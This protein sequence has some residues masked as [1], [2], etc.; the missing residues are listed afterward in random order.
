M[1][2]IFTQNVKHFTISS[3]PSSPSTNLTH[4]RSDLALNESQRLRAI[5]VDILL[6]G[7]GVIAIAAVRV[8][9]VAVRLDDAGVGGRAGEACWA[10]GKLKCV[11][12]V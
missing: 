5:L 12:K 1:I 6:M 9:G 4:L 10:G 3:P 8:R 11:S 7:V 2:L